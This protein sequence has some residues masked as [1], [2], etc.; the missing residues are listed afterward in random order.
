[1]TKI[2]IIDDCKDCPHIL[3]GCPNTCQAKNNKI[4]PDM[5]FNNAII[6]TWCPLNDFKK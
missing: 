6:P 4:I 5:I 1:M 3:I 2:Y